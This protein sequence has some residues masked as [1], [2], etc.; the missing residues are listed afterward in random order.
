MSMDFHSSENLRINP[1]IRAW[2]DATVQSQY[3]TST[4]LKTLVLAFDQ[5]I[6][7][8]EDQ[9]LFYRFIFNV[10]SAVGVGLDIWGRIVGATRD[11]SI[12][13]YGDYLGFN[14]SQLSPFNQAP[15]WNGRPASDLYRMSDEAFR[16]LIMWKAMANISTSDMASL[17][18]LTN[19]LFEDG[20]DVYLLESGI[21]TIRMVIESEL[22]PYQRAIFKKYGLFAKGAGVLFEW[23]EVP[24]PVFGF[25]GSDMQPFDQAPFFVNGLRK[26]NL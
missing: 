14:G 10:D 20:A 1:N 25:A 6:D 5:Q 2:D 7:P 8:L 24:V 18:S 4:V 26:H 3:S 15:F 19:I 11:I 9:G 13:M 22:E 23:L 17:N 12:E 16:R 21:M